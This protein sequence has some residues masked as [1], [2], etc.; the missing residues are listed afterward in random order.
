MALNWKV[1]FANQLRFEVFFFKKK[2]KNIDGGAS[3]AVGSHFEERIL[4]D[5]LMTAAPPSFAR[6]SKLLVAALR[7]T[8]WY[9]VSDA[10]A[11]DMTWGRNAGCAFLTSRCNDSAVWNGKYQICTEGDPDKYDCNYN[12]EQ[13][14][15]CFLR[16]YDTC[17]PSWA[18]YF[19]NV[20][21][22]IG[23]VEFVDFCPIVS[24]QVCLL[25]RSFVIALMKMTS[26][27]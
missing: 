6:I 11:G 23:G 27:L 5:E 21:C 24:D 13:F 16:R 7:D 17:L 18:Q 15:P 1:L 20:S 12:R 9:E 4:L 2:T 10:M 26:F 19:G 3:T 14:G 22:A 25:N 8:G